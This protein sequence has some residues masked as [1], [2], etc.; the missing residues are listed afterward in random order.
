MSI[1]EHSFGLT[2]NFIEVKKYIL[3]NKNKMEVKIITY[4]GAVVE[5]N[6]P[7]RNGN[8]SDVVLGY[9]NIEAYENGKKFHGALIGRCGNRIENSKFTINN[10][11]FLCRPM[12]FQRRHA[13]DA[14][15]SEEPYL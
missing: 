9:D 5:I 15:E 12:F 8:F 14:A 4:G 1:I 10:K 3:T 7:D 2:K 11:Q 13:S 6:V